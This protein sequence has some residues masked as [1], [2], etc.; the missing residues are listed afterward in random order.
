[1]YILVLSYP[2]ELEGKKTNVVLVCQDIV[3]KNWKSKSKSRHRE[4]LKR[5]KF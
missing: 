4:H 3:S 1:M 5:A 2:F